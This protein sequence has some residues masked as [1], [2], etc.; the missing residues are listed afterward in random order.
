MSKRFDTFDNDRSRDWERVRWDG[1]RYDFAEG[2]IQAAT[3]HAPQPHHLCTGACCDDLL[4]LC[5]VVGV[6]P[7]VEFDDSIEPGLSYELREDITFEMESAMMM[8]SGFHEG[9]RFAS[10]EPFRGYMEVPE[11]V[12]DIL[13]TPYFADKWSTD[14]FQLD[15][16]PS[17]ET[18]MRDLAYAFVTVAF[19]DWYLR[20]RVGRYF[21]TQQFLEP[22][23][24]QKLRHFI[25]KFTDS[26]YIAP[27]MTERMLEGL[28]LDGMCTRHFGDGEEQWFY[29]AAYGLEFGMKDASLEK[30][31][32][33]PSRWDAFEYF[34]RSNG[35]STSC[36]LVVSTG[37][38]FFNQ[39]CS[40]DE[41]NHCMNAY[42]KFM[43]P[44]IE[45]TPT[46]PGVMVVFSS[47]RNDAYIISAE[48]STWD[49]YAPQN[50]ILGP[51]PAEMDI[52][53]VWRGYDPRRYTPPSLD[54]L[55]GAQN[56]FVSAAARY[57]REC[58]S[59]LRPEDD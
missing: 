55:A 45:E 42:N 59:I 19:P 34:E 47:Y 4:K 26:G 20:D 29:G 11:F 14:E 28:D 24:G 58:L 16:R 57:M 53:G 18:Y 44:V 51:I 2:L 46:I 23:L 50:R 36:G 38:V 39:Q 41:L 5:P 33:T 12:G 49:E 30:Y 48:P 17:F 9:K 3:H 21:S 32:E 1:L 25:S 8:L 6:K 13:A 7:C 22:G 54:E 40:L 31:W 15:G 35:Y 37:G 56:P 10:K 43:F 27:L 52:V